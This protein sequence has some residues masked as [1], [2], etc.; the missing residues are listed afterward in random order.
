MNKTREELVADL[1][2]R[3]EDHILEPSNAALLAKLILHAADDNEALMIASLGTTYKRT[4]LHFDKRL[5]RPTSD[6]HYLRSNEALSFSTPPIQTTLNRH[7][8]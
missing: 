5:E 1:Q 8:A 7:I 4:G 2:R 3:V 6:V